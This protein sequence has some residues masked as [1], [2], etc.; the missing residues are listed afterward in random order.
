M[1]TQDFSVTRF[2][3]KQTFTARL[4]WDN[5]AVTFVYTKRNKI[6]HIG[7]TVFVEEWQEDRFETIM[8]R[9]ISLFLDTYFS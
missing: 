5:M 2:G 9:A 8:A 3:H 7:Y 6:N 4:D 1:Q